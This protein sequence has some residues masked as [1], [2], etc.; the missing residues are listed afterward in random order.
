MRL[1]TFAPRVGGRFV[2]R[3]DL[4]DDGQH[5]VKVEAIT[6]VDERKGVPYCLPAEKAC[7]PEDCGGIEPTRKSC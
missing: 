4:G 2:Y 6:P 3:Y 1:A 5:E 7:P